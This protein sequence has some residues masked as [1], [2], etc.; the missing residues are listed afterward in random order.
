MK[1]DAGKQERQQVSEYASKVLKER[2]Q[3]PGGTEEQEERVGKKED[4]E[5]G[6]TEGFRKGK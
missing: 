2:K 6:N 5:T 1:E 3:E 4:R